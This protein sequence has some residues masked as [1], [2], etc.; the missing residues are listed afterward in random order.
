MF[1]QNF[2]VVISEERISE[3]RISVMVSLER[4]SEERWKPG[5]TGRSL[6][7]FRGRSLKFFRG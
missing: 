6:K 4:I 3:E 2:L 5:K 7:I 1:S